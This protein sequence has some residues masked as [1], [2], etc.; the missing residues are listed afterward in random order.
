MDSNDNNENRNN[1]D[2]SE[3]TEEYSLDN[4]FGEDG[5]ES[6]DVNEI[7]QKSE[8][9]RGSD[10]DDGDNS[11]DNDNDEDSQEKT[12]SEESSEDEV[13]SQFTDD[14][15]EKSEENPEDLEISEEDKKKKKK[16]KFI[17]KISI[18]S[19]A[20]VVIIAAAIIATFV[21]PDF[22][23]NYFNNNYV[24][25]FEGR[26]ISVDDYQIFLLYNQQASDPKSSATDMLEQYLVLEKAAKDRNITLTSDEETQA[27]SD[28]S[29]LQSQINSYFPN[30]KNISLDFLQEISSIQYLYTKL[31][32]QVATE[33]GYTFNDADFQTAL[34]DYIANGKQDY[35]Q[36][37]FK[38]IVTN[39]ADTTAEAKKAIEDGTMAVDDAIKQ[40]CISPYYDAASGIQTIALADIT[41]LSADDLNSLMNLEAGQVSNVISL[42]STEYLIFI[43]DSVYRPTQDEI[44]T[45]YKPTYENGK[46][47]DIFQTQFTQW[48]AADKVKLNQKVID[49]IDLNALYGT[50]SSTDVLPDASDAGTPDSTDA[51][52]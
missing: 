4:K 17:M 24:L 11:N 32:D 14:G 8:T 51:T 50:Q 22:Y 46:K 6:E 1:I 2:E 44:S 18:I 15:G 45:S 21:Y 7:L 19:A 31:L 27:K 41:F 37:D 13:M 25:K 10:S 29:D 23:D 30:V 3:N 36:M 38:Y 16:S 43:A 12:E 20:C 39:S 33:N 35:L 40:Y 26:N 47:S 5:D 9:L 48:Q 34:T 42:S 28:A 49:N 52:T